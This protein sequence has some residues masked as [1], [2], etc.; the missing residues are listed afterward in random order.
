MVCGLSVCV[1][2]VLLDEPS[3]LMSDEEAMHFMAR[4]REVL[5]SVASL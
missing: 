4:L 3:L 5:V 1:Q 2:L